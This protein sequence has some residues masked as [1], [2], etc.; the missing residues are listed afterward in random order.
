[1]VKKLF[2]IM[3]LLIIII[4]SAYL[5][6]EDWVLEVCMDGKTLYIPIRIGDH[7]NLTYKHSVYGD[8]VLQVFTI[9][10]GLMILND[11][12]STVRVIEYSYPNQNYELIRGLARIKPLNVTA[13]KL[14]VIGYEKLEYKGRLI[15]INERP[16]K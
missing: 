13:K 11:I 5:L 14:Q 12:I 8:E 15:S 6:Q 16:M 1:M 3:M 10:E 9:D 2:I 4:T 7:F